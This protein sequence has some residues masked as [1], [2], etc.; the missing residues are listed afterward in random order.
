MCW[1]WPGWLKLW[2]HG[3]ECHSE[4]REK[5][6]KILQGFRGFFS[7]TCWYV[8]LSKFCNLSSV[9]W[10]QNH[11]DNA[12][13]RMRNYFVKRSFVDINDYGCSVTNNSFYSLENTR[14]VLAG[15]QGRPTGLL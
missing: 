9:K 11:P 6:S 3:V 14:L 7:S 1:G 12:A 8:I 15:V 2:E 10:G 13:A 5:Q 4:I